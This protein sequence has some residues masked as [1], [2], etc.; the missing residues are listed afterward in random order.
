[1]GGVSA[2]QTRDTETMAASKVAQWSHCVAAE[3]CVL[4]SSG[5]VGSVISSDYTAKSS[6]H[7]APME[8][9]GLVV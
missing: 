1:M 7:L 9:Q 3:Q 4:R 2:V 5:F 6:Q 8:T